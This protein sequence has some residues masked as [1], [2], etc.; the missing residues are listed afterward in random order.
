MAESR[1][2]Y[3][4]PLLIVEDDAAQRVG[5]QQLL[6]SWGFEVDAATAAARGG[7]IGT[8]SGGDAVSTGI[9]VTRLGPESS[10]SFDLSFR[11]TSNRFSAELTGFTTKLNDVYFD[12]ALVLPAPSMA[13][14]ANRCRPARGS[15][16][17]HRPAE[18]ATG[19]PLSVHSI[20][21]P[22]SLLLSRIGTPAPVT[23]GWV[24]VI[25]S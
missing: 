20:V 9:P 4:D 13:R 14:A 12:Q 15:L 21:E 16:S 8:T 11:Y 24:G 22:A 1:P 10:D 25:S 18:Q 23:T 19:R 17:S 5:L 6:K 3:P 2:A 7:F